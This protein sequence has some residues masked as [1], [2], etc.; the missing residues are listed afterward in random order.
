M[1]IYICFI[2]TKKMSKML[3]NSSVGIVLWNTLFLTKE[4]FSTK[5]NVFLI[6]IFVVG[7]LQI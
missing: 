1:V 5:W 4:H 6:M 3:K 7:T 2:N